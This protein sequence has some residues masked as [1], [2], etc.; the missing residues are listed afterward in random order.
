MLSTKCTLWA[1][2]NPSI[3]HQ[4]PSQSWGWLLKP[5]MLSA[6][7]A[8][9]AAENPSIDHQFPSLNLGIGFY[10]CICIEAH[11]SIIQPVLTILPSFLLCFLPP[12]PWLAS[13]LL[14]YLLT[15]CP[16]LACFFPSCLLL[17]FLLASFLTSCLISVC[18]FVPFYYLTFLPFFFPSFPL[19]YLLCFISCL[20]AY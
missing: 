12:F 1:V 10:P 4:F 5:V 15:S 9:W 3:A 16:P 14:P 7:C 2:E 11:I 20:P 17:S 18:F 19:S 13:F 8:L 6:K